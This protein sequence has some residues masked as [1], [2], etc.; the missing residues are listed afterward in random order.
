[1]ENLIAFKDQ[2]HILLIDN[3]TH[4]PYCE[5]CLNESTFIQAEEITRS[6]YKTIS[7]A[8]ARYLKGTA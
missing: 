1:M 7:L 6:T 3:I 5:R 8:K 4:F 2:G